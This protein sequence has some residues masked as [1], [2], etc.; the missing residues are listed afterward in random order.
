VLC[1]CL[2]SLVCLLLCCSVSLTV[3][4]AVLDWKSVSLCVYVCACGHLY[5]CM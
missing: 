1:V 3:M 5:T 4:V 2:C